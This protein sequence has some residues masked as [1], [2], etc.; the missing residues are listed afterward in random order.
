MDLNTLSL[1]TLYA[2]VNCVEYN[3]IQWWA[4]AVFELTSKITDSDFDFCFEDCNICLK[5]MFFDE[6]P[7]QLHGRNWFH[8]QLVSTSLTNALKDIRT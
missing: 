2:D 3:E 8:V 6:I 4:S 5:A 1:V 7:V